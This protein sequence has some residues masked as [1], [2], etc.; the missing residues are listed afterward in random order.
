M[1][2]HVPKMS[3]REKDLARRFIVFIDA[4]Y[5]SKVGDWIPVICLSIYSIFVVFLFCYVFF[6]CVFFGYVSY[7]FP[8]FVPLFLDVPSIPI[9]PP[10]SL[11]PHFLS[12]SIF[13]SNSLNFITSILILGKNSLNKR[14]PYRRNLHRRRS[15]EN[16]G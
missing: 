5:E 9:T 6:C 15:R 14:S 10:N 3:F 12:Y 2:T 8:P 16:G 1:I 4:V 7:T 11:Q 13:A